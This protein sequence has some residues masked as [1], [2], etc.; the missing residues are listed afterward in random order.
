MS[1]DDVLFSVLAGAIDTDLRADHNPT[2][3]DIAD[4]IPLSVCDSDTAL[5]VAKAA[6]SIS[7]GQTENPYPNFDF[8][9][10]SPEW[11]AK[12]QAGLADMEQLKAFR[13]NNF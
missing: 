12:R 8:G 1:Y 2:A 4:Q 13:N 5:D 11:L 3:K 9:P 10:H 7:M 6:I